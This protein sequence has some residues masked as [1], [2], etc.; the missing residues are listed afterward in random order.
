MRYNYDPEDKALLRLNQKRLKT[1]DI[2][3]LLGICEFALQD[4]TI[5]EGEAGAILD[6]LRNHRM[7]LET[8]PASVLY[9]RL[10]Q[11]LADGVLDADEQKDLLDI[12]MA[13]SRPRTTAGVIVPASLPVDEPAPAIVFTAR[14]FC[15]TGV[16]N[17][18]KRDDCLRAVV[19]RGGVAAKGITRGLNYLVI[20]NIGSEVWKHS[21]FGLKIAK[22]VDYRESGCGISIIDER[23]WVASLE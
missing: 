22:A 13:I 2:D 18:G 8:W 20:G 21:S 1:R 19:D 17:F 23:H 11:M 5:D 12:V 6:W 15:F 9:E 7:S 16:F 4:G 3:Q 10:S 14:S